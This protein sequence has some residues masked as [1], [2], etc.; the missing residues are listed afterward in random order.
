MLDVHKNVIY[1]PAV[2][3]W[4]DVQCVDRQWLDMGHVGF[5]ER[6]TRTNHDTTL[7]RS[8]M[9]NNTN[10]IARCSKKKKLAILEAVYIRDRDPAINRQMD[11][12]GTLSLCDGRPLAPRVWKCIYVMRCVIMWWCEELLRMFRM[13][14][15]LG[16]IE[17]FTVI[18]L[19]VPLQLACALKCE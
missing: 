15:F 9:V 18:P 5:G 6:H 4:F 12:R 7:T 8:M 17:V 3:V 13:Y 19:E 14:V 2:R 16:M 1:V 11:M 10:I